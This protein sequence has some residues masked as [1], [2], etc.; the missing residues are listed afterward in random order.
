M[1]KD[2]SAVTVSNVEGCAT[3]SRLSSSDVEEGTKVGH[4]GNTVL[5]PTPTNDPNDPL[6]W[7]ETKKRIILG[8]IAYIA[9]L[10][11]FGSSA[12]LPAFIPQA[13]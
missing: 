3:E 12:G 13:Q 2:E 6:N 4:D 8:V 5:I 9:F 11:D 7:K 1:E 10:P